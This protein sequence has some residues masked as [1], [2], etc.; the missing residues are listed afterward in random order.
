MVA[1]T[2]LFLHG[3]A[4]S[5]RSTKA[6]YLAGRFAA[7][8]GA[9]F[10][11]LDFNPTPA[12]FEYMT[13]TGLINRLRQYV[14]DRDLLRFRLIASSYGGLI[15]LHY[16]HRFGGVEEMLLLAPV[17]RWRPG[18]PFPERLALWR[19]E[20]VIRVPHYALGEELP[21]R[22]DIEIDGQRYREPV[23]PPCPVTIIHGSADGI[24]PAED[25]RR[26]AATFSAQV[27]LVEVEADHDLNGHLDLIWEYARSLAQ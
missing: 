15:A 21:L 8:P 19:E 13:T 4:S 20:G 14:L 1:K 16:A 17:L 12:D 6:R 9:K 22:Y 11:A 24:V 23:P 7:L 18:G 10:H 25:S 2:I 26:Y 3:F 27:R 5:S